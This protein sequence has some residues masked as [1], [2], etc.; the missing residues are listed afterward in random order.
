MRRGRCTL[1][2]RVNHLWDKFVQIFWQEEKFSS[3]CALVLSLNQLLLDPSFF[4]E[5][6]FASNDSKANGRSEVGIC[7]HRMVVSRFLSS[8]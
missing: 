7:F 8:R 6:E 5:F 3:M 4:A 1:S 2:W